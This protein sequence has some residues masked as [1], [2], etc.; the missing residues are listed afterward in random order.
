[1][2][3]FIKCAEPFSYPPPPTDQLDHARDLKFGM[4]DPWD[5][6]LGAI[7]AIFDMCPLSQDIRGVSGTPRGL[8]NR[9]IFFSKFWFFLLEFTNLRHYHGINAKN[10]RYQRFYSVFTKKIVTSWVQKF[11]HE[12]LGQG[13][14]I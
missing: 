6:T 9:K 2:P 13:I 8:K 12:L 5:I 11:P 3:P 1:M 10:E 7:E 14:E 4:D